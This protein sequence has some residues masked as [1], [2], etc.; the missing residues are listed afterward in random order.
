MPEENMSPEAVP[1][2]E[3]VDEQETERQQDGEDIEKNEGVVE[4]REMKMQAAAGAVADAFTS[5]WDK[6]GGLEGV[7]NS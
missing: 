3:H 6:R 5:E 2:G 7:L 1:Q 4:S